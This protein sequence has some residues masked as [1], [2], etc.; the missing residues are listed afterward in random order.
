MGTFVKGTT[1]Y[2]WCYVNNSYGNKWIYG[3][4]VGTQTKG[5]VCD[6]EVVH[7]KGTLKKC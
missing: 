1:F 3:R 6:S 7:T 4:I 2:Y 5:W